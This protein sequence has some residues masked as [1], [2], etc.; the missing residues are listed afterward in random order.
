MSTGYTFFE[1]NYGYHSCISSE[2]KA[3]LHLKIR[4]AD[5]LAKK[6]KNLMLVCQ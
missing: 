4:L 5:K 6:L 3:N 1:L 2:D